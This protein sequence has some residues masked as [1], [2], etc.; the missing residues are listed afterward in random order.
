MNAAGDQHCFSRKFST[1]NRSRKHDIPIR[2]GD[3]P[4]IF[5]AAADGHITKLEGLLCAFSARTRNIGVDA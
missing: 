4:L 5:F 2:K 3:I 1:D